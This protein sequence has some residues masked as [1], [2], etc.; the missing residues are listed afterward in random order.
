MNE[1]AIWWT[2]LADLAILER[3]LDA[4]IPVYLRTL[5]RLRCHLPLDSPRKIV[6]PSPESLACLCPLWPAT[7]LAAVLSDTSYVGIAILV[8]DV[9]LLDDLPGIVTDL[10]L[11]RYSRFNFTFTEAASQ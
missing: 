7:P 11:R 10:N 9:P 5:H 8:N 1:Y 6:S 4:P 3:E 2:N